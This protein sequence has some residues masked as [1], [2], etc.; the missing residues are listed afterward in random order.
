MASSMSTP[1]NQ[2][3]ANKP[4][5]ATV[6]EDPE[7]LNV[8]KEMEEEVKTAT[9]ANAQHVVVPHVQ[10]INIAPQPH[11]MI[12]PMHPPSTRW[13]DQQAVQ[14]A[15]IVAILALVAFYPNLLDNLYNT[16][17]YLEMLAKF[18]LIV[19]AALLSVA[20]YI[21]VVHFGI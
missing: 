19:R 15:G 7:V 3:P 11:H 14:H 18:D 21:A 17:P 8:L 5:T 1:I 2:L 12:Q 6:P 20:V 13:I 16:S 10:H 4:V 9:K